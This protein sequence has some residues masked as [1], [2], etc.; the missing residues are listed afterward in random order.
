M[1]D[2]DRKLLTI[3]QEDSTR[4]IS[5]IAE[6]VG[7]TNTPCWR[8]LQNLEDQGVIRKRV[9]LLNPDKMNLSTTAFVAVKT[10]QHSQAWLDGF[11]KAVQDIPEVMEFYRMS[12]ETDYLMRVVVPDMAGYDAVYKR[13]I[14][15][16]DLADVTSSFA[17]EQ[18]K[19]T[20][21][22]PISYVK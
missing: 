17:M 2:I 16:V 22:L 15:K 18:I 5:D 6:R 13:L 20:T 14:E 10:N 1:D 8:R 19:Y 9:A 7:L 21:A 3:I 12:G 4:S 11:A